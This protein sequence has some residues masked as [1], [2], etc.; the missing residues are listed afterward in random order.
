MF[1]YVRCQH[2]GESTSQRNQVQT[3]LVITCKHKH[4]CQLICKWDCSCKTTRLS[5]VFDNYTEYN[6]VFK[7]LRILFI[8]LNNPFDIR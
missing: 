8:Y 2:Q 6:Y 4:I 7:A 3:A 5:F 1:T